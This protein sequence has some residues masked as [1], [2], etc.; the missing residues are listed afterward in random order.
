MYQEGA[1]PHRRGRVSAG[2]RPAGRKKWET[3]RGESNLFVRKR[4]LQDYLLQKGYE[5]DRVSAAVRTV[6][7]KGDEE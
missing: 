1:D 6:A 3:L 7:G 4:K 5:S 2:P